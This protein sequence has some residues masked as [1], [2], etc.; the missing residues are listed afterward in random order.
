MKLLDEIVDLLADEKSSLSAALLKMKVL[1]HKIGHQ[2]LVEWVNKELNGYSESDELPPYRVLHGRLLA[3]VVS[4]AYRA[5]NF[6]L[7]VR[8]LSK[9]QHERLTT[10]RLGHSLASIELLT[11]GDGQTIS[12]PI[13]PE[14]N[15]ALGE[16]LEKGNWVERAGSA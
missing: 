4:F 9:P 6:E 1:L 10:I 13:P 7:P 12:Q 2:E 14:F 5:T 11:K 3:D 8:H 15:G 16:K